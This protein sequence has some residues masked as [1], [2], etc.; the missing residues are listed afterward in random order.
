MQPLT[1]N[2]IKVLIHLQSNNTKITTLFSLENKLLKYSEINNEN[3]PIYTMFTNK[4]TINSL[5]NKKGLILIKEELRYNNYY[6]REYCINEQVLTD[7][8]KKN[9]W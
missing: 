3:K 9:H 2:Q 7:L 1:K 6:R 4:N 8:Y 5:I